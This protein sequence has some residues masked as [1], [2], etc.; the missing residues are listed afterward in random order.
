MMPRARHFLRCA[1][2]LAAT[3]LASSP[4]Q[5]QSAADTAAAYAAAA[6]TVS[7]RGITRVQAYADYGT[8]S[9][10]AQRGVADGIG[11][12]VDER[13][14]G[15]GLP[16]C[17][18]SQVPDLISRGASLVPGA[19]AIWGPVARVRIGR[20]CRSWEDAHTKVVVRDDWVV[21][22]RTRG[23]WSRVLAWHQGDHLVHEPL[24]GHGADPV[25][26]LT[27]MTDEWMATAVPFLVAALLLL[28]LVA[29]RQASEAAAI[30]AADRSRRDRALLSWRAR[31]LGPLERVLLDSR[32]HL[33]DAWRT[34]DAVLDQ[35]T[36]ASHG[37]GAVAGAAD[38]VPRQRSPRETAG[39]LNARA[40]TAWAVGTVALLLAV[41]PL[42]MHEPG[43]WRLLAAITYCMM[44]APIVLAVGMAHAVA[45]TLLPFRGQAAAVASI[46]CGALLGAGVSTACGRWFY[47]MPA[48]GTMIFAGALYGGLVT[49]VPVAPPRAEPTSQ[50]LPRERRAR[51]G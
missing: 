20:L 2:L 51:G 23:H 40:R 32:R 18:R 8:T 4:V 16:Q 25:L 35:A 37:A 3:L 31:L 9:V 22:L 28:L 10:A 7:R 50:E 21:L 38:P 41:V 19:L 44:G 42:T 17:A 6:R 12:P 26:R 27:P 46:G 1:L 39:G 15:F 36:A 29:N 5:G 48:L 43:N 13:L 45:M 47:A 34:T 11:I 33:R 30:P 49:I 14:A 24:A